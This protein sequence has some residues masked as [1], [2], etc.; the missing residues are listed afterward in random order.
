MKPIKCK[1][2]LIHLDVNL[3]TVV[4]D[5]KTIKRNVFTIKQLQYYMCDKI[6]DLYM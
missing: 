4:W 5:N 1:C 6:R 2:N 3:Y